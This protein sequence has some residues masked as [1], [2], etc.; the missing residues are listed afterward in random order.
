M[1]FH[2]LRINLLAVSFIA[3]AALLLAGCSGRA[4]T[5][6][7]D[8]DTAPPTYI[9]I[10]TPAPPAF[11]FDRDAI[12]A[13][14]GDALAGHVS[15]AGVSLKAMPEFI[16]YGQGA[17]AL[18]NPTD[19]ILSF[20]DHFTIER[21]ISGEW[22][23]LANDGQFIVFGIGF[24]VMPGDTMVFV[25][26]WDYRYGDLASGSYRLIKTAYEEIWHFASLRQPSGHE[27]PRRR[28]I[29][30]IAPFE[31]VE[32]QNP[33]YPFMQRGTF[34]MFATNVISHRFSESLASVS[35]PHQMAAIQSAF[36]WHLGSEIRNTITSP[37]DIGTHT[38]TFD[39]FSEAME[40]VSAVVF[41]GGRLAASGL[42]LSEGESLD[43][44]ILEG[45]ER[46][47]LR[48]IAGAP[49]Y[50]GGATADV[51]ITPLQGQPRPNPPDPTITD[52]FANISKEV[53]AARPDQISI[54][55]HNPSSRTISYSEVIYL[56]VLTDNGWQSVPREEELPH[57]HSVNTLW[58]GEN[59]LIT[60]NWLLVYGELA[61]G[62]YRIGKWYAEQLHLNPE[63]NW[64]LRRSKVYV[65]FTI[66]SQEAE[67]VEGIPDVSLLVADRFQNFH[68][69]G[70]PRII[71][72]SMPFFS[73]TFEGS[74]YVGVQ[75]IPYEFWH[76]SIIQSN[77][78]LLNWHSS[79]IARSS[80]VDEGSSG[81]YSITF[82]N[83]SEGMESVNATIMIGNRPALYRSN[84]AEG[85]AFEFMALHA[86]LLSPV[87]VNIATTDSSQTTNT[88]RITINRASE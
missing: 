24:F 74:A 41:V 68:M 50:G 29:T 37:E 39:N 82:D 34:D 31:V 18:H 67:G 40:L 63:A 53:L 19:Q 62:R 76:P 30:L 60:A 65:E 26:S 43:F 13:E 36:Q 54:L 73:K 72:Q 11:T 14:L 4:E 80:F 56:E 57:F 84:I 66:T 58:P 38:L 12:A 1:V 55:L 51:S 46:S 47:L 35:E 78:D 48:I 71:R 59:K 44:E 33:D 21:N 15:L 28:E 2:K 7:I 32:G 79:F 45:E 52:N 85:D 17:F 27:P 87:H 77:A 49:M 22:V 6:N 83:F 10:Q 42:G 20:G 9:P 8:A 81:L 69:A 70:T 5:H 75:Y 23:R 86:E 61:P 25:K 88:A 64:P 3:S 16:A